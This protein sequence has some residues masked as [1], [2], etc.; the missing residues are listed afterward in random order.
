MLFCAAALFLQSFSGEALV[1]ISVALLLFA[2]PVV[3][4]HCRL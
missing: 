1:M 4:S 2:T 3:G